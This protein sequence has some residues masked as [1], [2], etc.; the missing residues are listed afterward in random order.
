MNQTELEAALAD[1]SLGGVRYFDSI[2]ST[3]DEASR[4][5]A[6]GAPDLALVIADEQTSGRGRAGRRWYTRREAALAFSLVIYPTLE[7]S[8]NVSRMT[9]LGALAVCD[10]LKNHYQLPAKIKWPND[11]LV[12]DKKVAGILVEAQW[13]GDKLGSFIL[14]IGINVAPASI[15]DALAHEPVLHFP[16][17]CIDNALGRPVDRVKLLYQ[18][19]AGIRHWHTRLIA[20][21]FLKAWESNLAYRHEWIQVIPGG[22]TGE[23]SLTDGIAPSLSREGQVV[24][25]SNDG[26]LLIKSRTGEILTLQFGEVR[27]RPVE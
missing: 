14:G 20:P 10:A 9:A 3:N 22:D 17:T 24:G 15:E 23:L 26:S 21:D 11:V 5:A 25:L 8:G 4:W 2:G 12:E 27:L 1:L 16:S 13:T 19:M 6:Q 7:E 18:V